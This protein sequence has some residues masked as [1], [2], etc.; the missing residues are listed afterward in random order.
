MTKRQ[1]ASAAHRPHARRW[2]E[3]NTCS[4]VWCCCTFPGTTRRTKGDTSVHACTTSSCPAHHHP[5]WHLL[6]LTSR[7]GARQQIVADFLY[8]PIFLCSL[9]FCRL[10]KWIRWCRHP[11]SGPH[12]CPRR[13]GRGPPA[14][15]RLN[16][17]RQQ[18]VMSCGAPFPAIFCSH[19][20]NHSHQKA[21]KL[22]LSS[23]QLSV[24]FKRAWKHAGVCPNTV[25]SLFTNL[26]GWSVC[27]YLLQVSQCGFIVSLA[28]QGGCGRRAVI[29]S[30]RMSSVTGEGRP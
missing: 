6:S 13:G 5:P 2:W 30:A 1:E 9:A 28:G 4:P 27:I 19:H 22:S 15:Y 14:P 18:Q 11:A 24:C 17:S 7:C 12:A 10:E 23:R 25:R 26:C 29:I 3:T 16:L 20:H 21:F 8:L